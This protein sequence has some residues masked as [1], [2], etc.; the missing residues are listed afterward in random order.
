MRV[1]ISNI[2]VFVGL[3]I[4]VALVSVGPHWVLREGIMAATLLTST[5]AV[6][7]WPDKRRRLFLPALIAHDVILTALLVMYA[8]GIRPDM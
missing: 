2:G 4:I 3:F 5:V 7:L 8:V 1:T 6:M